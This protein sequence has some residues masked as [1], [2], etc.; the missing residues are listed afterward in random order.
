MK[1]STLLLSFALGLASV[2]AATAQTTAPLADCAPGAIERPLPEYPITLRKTHVTTGLA[3]VAI[4]IDAE[5]KLADILVI[6]YTREE[7]AT[8]TVNALKKWRFTPAIRNG[9]PVTAQ[10]ELT[11]HFENTGMVVVDDVS[12]IVETFLH[13]NMRNT[14]ITYKPA[15]L[16]ELDRIPTPISATA[17]RYGRDLSEKGI[18][19]SVLVEFF[20]DENGAIRMPAV[21]KAD[22]PELASLAIDAITTWKFEPP[23]CRRQPV[24]VRAQ[25]VFKFEPGKPQP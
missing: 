20:I 18:H 22:H 25:Q 21:L 6:R 2:G 4:C 16:Q 24:L 9:V 15:T 3:Q 8:A 23:L 17:P 7:F 19:G 12:S 11:F 1:A 13:G 5:G 14:I 10:T